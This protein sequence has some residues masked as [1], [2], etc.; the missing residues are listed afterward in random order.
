MRIV[1]FYQSLI[2]DWNHG[3]AHFLR[4]I[5]SELLAR[6]HDVQIYEPRNSWSVQNLIEHNG[7]EPLVEFQKVYPQ[8]LS[9]RYDLNELKLEQ[10]LE[11]ADL[12]I[13]HEWNEAELI[14]R[15]GEYRNVTK[16]FL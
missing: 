9:K 11:G 4:G 12:V 5:A 10:V 3:N 8:L 14:E 7:S 13:V 2:S 16:N 6:G 15:I 1:L